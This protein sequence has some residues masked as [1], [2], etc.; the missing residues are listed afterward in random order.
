MSLEDRLAQPDSWPKPARRPRHTHPAGWEPGIDTEKGVVTARVDSPDGPDWTHV[1][2]GLG[3]DPGD[4][5]VDGD[6][7]EV[8]SW[9]QA[10]GVRCYYFKAKVSPVRAAPPDLD[11]EK[12]AAQVRTRGPLK[13]ASN[14]PPPTGGGGFLC[15]VLTDWQAGK[16]TAG[17]AEQLVG[18]L[19]RLGREVELRTGRLRDRGVPVPNLA[20]LLGGDL[21]EGCGGN[22][23]YAMQDFEV[24]LDMRQQTKL[25]RRMLVELIDRWAPRFERVVV[26]A[27]A[28][29]HGEK[30]VGGKAVT[31]WSDN[32]DVEI[33]E[34]VA[35]I[36]AANPDRYGHV[37]FRLPDPDSLCVT[38]DLDGLVVAVAHGH[39]ARRGGSGVQGKVLKW[40]DAMAASRHPV[41]DADALVTGHF[42]HFEAH[43]NG[44][45]DGRGRMWLQ[46]P[47][48]DG[49]SP[50][51]EQ[52]GGGFTDAGTLT[53]VAQGGRLDHLRIIPADG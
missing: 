14:P 36:L 23:H 13:A 29:N 49:G 24:E 47:A 28:G 20:L 45:H 52:T 35:E 17:G 31:S 18:R 30:R 16:G 41:G 33:P 12:L 38:V 5:Q 34:Q 9:D 42:H 19:E 6:T 43:H 32:L 27:A 10:P 39:Q 3:L 21:V 7:A 11:I 22:P 44:T 25:V 37:G 50:W 8:R 15:V 46:A 2:Q 1:L 40:W 53:F 4:W 51:F 48:L 26:A